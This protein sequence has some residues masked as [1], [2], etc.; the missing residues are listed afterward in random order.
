[1]KTKLEN[2]ECGNWFDFSGKI[3]IKGKFNL[4]KPGGFLTTDDLVKEMLGEISP[5]VEVL[6]GEHLYLNDVCEVEKNWWQARFIQDTEEIW[7]I[8]KALEDGAKID[9][10]SLD[11][12]Q[13]WSEIHRDTYKTKRL[14]YGY[15]KYRIQPKEMEKVGKVGYLGFSFSDN[16]KWLGVL[17]SINEKG[18]FIGE[19]SSTEYDKFR[20]L[21][22]EELAE[23]NN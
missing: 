21:S 3:Y 10:K 4:S 22:K 16:C 8:Q 23:L 17:K 14:L 5:C 13:H 2:I 12:E 18:K 11:N 6:S 20:V 1:M 9:M 7:I 19:M 15:F